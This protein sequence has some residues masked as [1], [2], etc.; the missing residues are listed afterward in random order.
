MKKLLALSVLL[1][2]TFANGEPLVRPSGNAVKNDSQIPPAHW[3]NGGTTALN[4]ANFG[5]QYGHGEASTNA[6]QSP[7]THVEPPLIQPTSYK[8]TGLSVPIEPDHEPN[9]N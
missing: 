5:D 2:S 7:V 4:T 9:L 1:L 6:I 8:P 3:G